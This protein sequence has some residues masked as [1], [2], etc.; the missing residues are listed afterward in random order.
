MLIADT[1][2]WIEFL[3]KHEPYHETLKTRLETGQVFALECVFGELLQ[4]A[5]SPRERNLI[6]AYWNNL[7]HLDERNIFIEAGRYAGER[8]LFAQGIG[9]IDAVLLVA[10]RRSGAPIWT[11]DTKLQKAI[12]EDDKSRS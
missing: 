1:S 3:K 6:E 5:K 2:I 12:A 7:P 10:S 9:L 11:L 4:G 8:G